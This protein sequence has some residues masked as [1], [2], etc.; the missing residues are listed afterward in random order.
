M[1]PP[2]KS[3]KRADNESSDT[4]GISIE[5]S[6]LRRPFC[7]RRC[8]VYFA[9]GVW[10]VLFQPASEVLNLL[11]QNLTRNHDFRAQIRRKVRKRLQ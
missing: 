10:F 1:S 9:L 5:T 6:D 11:P 3:A 4:G 7:G 2:R 8:G